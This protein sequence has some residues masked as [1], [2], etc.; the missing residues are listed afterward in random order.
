MIPETASRFS[1]FK[2]RYTV[3]YRIYQLRISSDRIDDVVMRGTT[4]GNCAR[5]TFIIVHRTC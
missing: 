4:L 3:V 5:D 1:L 2:T